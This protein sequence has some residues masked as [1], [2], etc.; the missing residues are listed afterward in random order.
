MEEIGKFQIEFEDF[1][2]NIKH[3]CYYYNKEYCPKNPFSSV[4]VGFT[5]LQK[6]LIKRS[7]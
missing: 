3:Y 2:N 4:T 7:I 1:G 5:N 6:I